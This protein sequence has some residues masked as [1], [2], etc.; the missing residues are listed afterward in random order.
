MFYNSYSLLTGNLLCINGFTYSHVSSAELK[1]LLFVG[2]FSV[3]YL[4]LQSA[5]TLLPSKNKLP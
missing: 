1:N 4:I 2:I 3:L 5:T